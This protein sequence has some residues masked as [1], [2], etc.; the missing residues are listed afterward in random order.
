MN[1]ITYTPKIEDL[2]FREKL[3]SDSETMSYN[4]AW[5][6]TIPFPK[7]KQNDWFDWWIVNHDG[8]DRYYRYLLDEESNEFVGEIAYHLDKT[9]GIYLANIIIYSKYRGKGYGTKGLSLLLQSAKENG[10]FELYD[11]IAADNQ[12]IKMFLNVGFVIEYKTK[13][14]VMLRKVL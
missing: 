8:N 7:E 2:W 5:G 10:L 11:A 6:G 13:D 12:S 14:I 1:L 4:A 3:L 9:K